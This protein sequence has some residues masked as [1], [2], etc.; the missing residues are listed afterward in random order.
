MESVVTV[1]NICL[2]ILARVRIFH[3]CDYEKDILMY[4]LSVSTFVRVY[5]YVP[6]LRMKGLT[7]FI[8]IRHSMIFLSNVNP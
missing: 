8:N 5:G 7:D 3:L 1:N 6:R 2:D 4:P